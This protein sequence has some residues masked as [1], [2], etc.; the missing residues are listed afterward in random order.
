MAALLFLG[1]C[2]THLVES[3][4]DRLPS[5]TR[6]VLTPERTKEIGAA[7]D[8]TMLA[9]APTAIDHLGGLAYRVALAG[10]TISSAP[11][12]RARVDRVQADLLA[13]ARSGHY[14]KTARAFDWELRVVEDQDPNAFALPGG[15]VAVTTGLLKFTRDDDAQLAA[16][17]AHE[18]VHA[19]GRHLAQSITK[20]LAKQVD[21]LTADGLDLTRGGMASP[22]AAS[23]LAVMGIA[24]LG[25]VTAPFVRD[26]ELEADREG[27]RLMAQAGYDPTAAITFWE[28]HARRGQSRTAVPA[29]FRMHP[30]DAVRIGQLRASLAEALGQYRPRAAA[31][32]SQT[33]GRS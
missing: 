20:D 8:G 11:V 32:S 10:K 31:A 18:M 9:L 2:S 16:V 5:G 12:L 14:A 17:M 24:H 13:A 22:A 3:V 15:K 30:A 6:S 33:G 27:Q 28:R 26:Q 25:Q 4:R 29:F 21:E 19:L 7:A 1:G 23:L